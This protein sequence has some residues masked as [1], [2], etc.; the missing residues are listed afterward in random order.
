MRLI[1]LTV[2]EWLGPS[3]EAALLGKSAEQVRDRGFVSYHLDLTTALTRLRAYQDAY[4][5]KYVSCEAV[6]FSVIGINVIPLDT[7]DT[8]R[9]VPG[10][11]GVY[12]P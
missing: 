12:G 7:Y 10:K 6:N 1:F 4:N 2:R 3:R 9:H 5:E 8:P 11:D